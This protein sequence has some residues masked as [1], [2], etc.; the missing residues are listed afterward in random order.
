M[1]SVTVTR[2]QGAL[3]VWWPR[4]WV[5]AGALWRDGADGGGTAA[6]GA[7]VGP[8]PPRHHAPHGAL[9][10]VQQVVVHPEADQGDHPRGH[11][12]CAGH[13]PPSVIA[14]PGC[15]GCSNG[16][17]VY[18]SPGCGAMC[19]LAFRTDNRLPSH[20][21]PWKGGALCS[22]RCHA[23]MHGCANA[24]QEH[25]LEGH[26][27]S[28][29]ACLGLRGTPHGGAHRQEVMPDELLAVAA[30]PQV[31]PGSHVGEGG[32]L[33][34]VQ[35]LRR[36][37]PKGN[38]PPSTAAGIPPS[39]LPHRASASP[40]RRRV[41][42][43]RKQDLNNSHSTAPFAAPAAPRRVMYAVRAAANPHAWHA[44]HWLQGSKQ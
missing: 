27:E 23:S 13:T 12:L 6:D 37:S 3:H 19:S 14:S 39:Q 41:P 34:G 4:Q 24:L 40:F 5:L 32:G 36:R 31:V 1:N 33:P 18:N 35:H 9:R 2:H 44:G 8:R 22:R 42:L 28:S 15:G 25:R 26:T 29:R 10:Q 43:A 38:L 16:V 11:H 20:F 30:P 7:H 17:I 21:E